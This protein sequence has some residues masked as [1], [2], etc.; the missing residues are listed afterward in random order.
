MIP[1]FV[2]RLREEIIIFLNDAEKYP[3]FKCISNYKNLISFTNFE[4]PPNTLTF[5]GGF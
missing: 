4:Y 3:E 5:V 1:N 2:R